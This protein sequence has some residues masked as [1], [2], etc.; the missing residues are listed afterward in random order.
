MS[1]WILENS[2]G[3]KAVVAN[4]VGFRKVMKLDPIAQRFEV[5]KVV[6]QIPCQDES[7]GVSAVIRMT[8]EAVG[9][10]FPEINS[11]TL[12]VV[13][14]SGNLL[15]GPSCKIGLA[16]GTGTARRTILEALTTQRKISTHGGWVVHS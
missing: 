5:S 16:K 4:M 11:R 9:A 15:V 7:A 1:I 2:D 6:G 8:I 10:V 3:E 14:N 12:K 13:D